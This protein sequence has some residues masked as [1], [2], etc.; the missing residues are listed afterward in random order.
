[1]RSAVSTFNEIW[2]QQ[3]RHR[4]LSQ[5]QQFSESIQFLIGCSGGMDSMLLLYLMA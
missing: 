5:T 3:F 2:Q 4:V 1:M